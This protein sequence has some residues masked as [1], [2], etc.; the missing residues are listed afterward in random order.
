LRVAFDATAAAW[1][2]AGIGR[3]GRGLLKALPG[4]CDQL[5]I[6]AFYSGFRRSRLLEAGVSEGLWSGTR[7]P[8]HPRISFA[9]WHKLRLPVPVELFAGRFDVLHSPDFVLPPSICDR[10]IVTIH[11]LTYMTHPQ[12]AVP[13]LRKHL[14]K[15]V[16]RSVVSADRII[17]VSKETSNQITKYYGVPAS[18]IDVIYNG[19]DT[20]FLRVPRRKE[21]DFVRGRYALPK[22]FV[23]VVGTLQP[24]KNLLK[25]VEA[26]K[27]VRQTHDDLGLIHVGPRGWISEK[28]LS[29]IVVQGEGFL[30]LL[31]PVP[32]A[33]L[34][35]IYSQATMTAAVSIAEGFMLPVVESMAVGT[36]VITSNTSCMPEIAGGAAVLVDPL[37]EKSIADSIGALIDDGALYEDL[38]E[39]G[40]ARSASFSWSD[41][42]KKTVA[43]YQK[44]ISQ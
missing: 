33:Q 35:A 7:I 12:T 15:S 44:V 38:V 13:S 36:P 30:Q 40:K 42:A 20:K 37:D 9:L 23:L 27:L 32:D 22:R 39:R 17:A 28:E 19:V 5:E 16:E 10:R 43:C 4:A 8:L 34:P 6:K 29:D 18:K 26:V 31:G 1:Q 2:I 14:E 41:A 21:V 24:R 11:D 3:V 25:V